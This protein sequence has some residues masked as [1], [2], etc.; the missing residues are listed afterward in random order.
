MALRAVEA[1]TGVDKWPPFEGRY[2]TRREAVALIAE[3]GSNFIAAFDA[4][5]ETPNVNVRLAQRGDIVALADAYG[6]K[7]L[8]VCI[9]AETAFLA[10]GGLVRVPTMTCLCCWRV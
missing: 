5:F 4:F 3:H 6:E 9:G 1:L 2:R 8:G 7:H 10:P